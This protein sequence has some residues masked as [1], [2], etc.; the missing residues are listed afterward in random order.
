MRPTNVIRRDNA[1]EANSDHIS[2][3]GIN[4]K[5][6]PKPQSMQK[7]LH[8]NNLLET[9][10]PDILMVLETGLLADVK[11]Y[12]VHNKYVIGQNNPVI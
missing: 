4:A 2:F 1:Q 6:W 3:I 8:L 9:H 12:T 10:Q 5:S 7:A 11:P